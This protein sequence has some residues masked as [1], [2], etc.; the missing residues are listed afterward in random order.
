MCPH[1]LIA[2]ALEKQ[3]KTTLPMPLFSLFLQ[4]KTRL[5]K[6]F[7]MKFQLHYLLLCTRAT[8]LLPGIRVEVGR[9][10]A[11]VGRRR[12]DVSFHPVVLGINL[13]LSGFAASSFIPWAA[14]PTQAPS[15]DRFLPC[16]LSTRTLRRPLWPCSFLSR[17]SSAEIVTVDYVLPFHPLPGNICSWWGFYLFIF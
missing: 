12:A 14:S 11:E 4:S 7:L 5:R 8:R 15:F 9:R 10:R 1:T 16:K 3:N 17:E 2:L 13:R 6:L